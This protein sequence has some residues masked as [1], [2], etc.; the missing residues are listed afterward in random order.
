MVKRPTKDDAK[1]ERELPCVSKATGGPVPGVDVTD[2][3]ELQQAE[4]LAY[5]ERLNK[6]Q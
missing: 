1:S 5:I 4:D 6:Q 2:L 3:S